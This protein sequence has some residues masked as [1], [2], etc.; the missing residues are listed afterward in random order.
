[1]MP[2]TV[3]AKTTNISHANLMGIFLA[4]FCLV[5]TTKEVS[6]QS[7]V[8]GPSV[9][10]SYAID[11]S[12]NLY[13]WGRNTVSQLG[14]G[15]TGSY[16]APD[17]VSFPPGVTKWIAVAGGSQG[18][19]NG[20]AVAVGNDGNAYAWGHGGN[21][22]MGDG[23][24]NS[25]G[26]PNPVT[27]PIGIKFTALAA[28]NNH[29]LALGNDGNVYAWGYNNKGQIGDGSFINR[30]TPFL[31]P[32]PSGITA[33]AI[34]AGANYSMA[35]RSDDSIEVWGNDGNGQLLNGLINSTGYSTPFA[36]SLPNG[37]K[38][39]A[40]SCGGFFALVLAND[41][42]LYGWGSA[43]KGQ[44]TGGDTAGLSYLTPH[45][46]IKPSGVTNWITMSGGQNY[47]MA[48]GD[49][50][51]LYATGDGSSGQLGDGVTDTS[52][53]FK[54]VV[55]PNGA[56]PQAISSGFATSMAS[57]DD[58]NVYAWG[59]N[60][61]GQVGIGNKVSPQTSPVQVLG[62]E[63]VGFLNLG[64]ISTP[65]VPVLLSPANS[66]ADQPVSISISWDSVANATSY[67]FQVSTDQTFASNLVANGISTDTSKALTGLVNSTTYYWRVR[68]IHYGAFSA[69]S[70]VRS[71]TTVSQPPTTPVLLSPVDNATDEPRNDTLVCSKA[72]NATHY[73]WQL[74]TN[75]SF[76][77]F[78]VNDSTTDT[79]RVV[80]LNAATKYYWQVRAVNP[81]GV[82][83]FGGP[84]S[85]T[86]INP[87]S[88]APTLILPA[89]NAT[90]Q[91]ADTL[92]T[93]W[94]S[95]S[96]ASGYAFQLSDTASFTR[97]TANDS[98]TDTMM[99]VTK[100]K[101]SQ[102]YYWRVSALNSG[103]SGPFSSADS[104]TTRISVPDVPVLVLPAAYVTGVPRITTFAWN[105]AARSNKYELQVST[106]FH[107]YTSG[108]SAGA[109]LKQN[110]VF[111][112]TTTDT[113]LQLHS[114]LAV[115]TKYYWHVNATD[116]AGWSGYANNPLFYFTT[117][118]ALSVGDEFDGIPKD[119][120]LSQNYPNPFNPS[121]TINYDLPKAQ[122]VTLKLYNVLGQEV[123]TLVNGHQNAGYYEVNFNASNLGSGVY[124]YVLRTEAFTSVHKM[125][126][127]K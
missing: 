37:L 113:T 94:H 80:S 1:M 77:S 54:N 2:S 29:C 27:M 96:K 111:D 109:F 12:G 49:N 48:I 62:K 86:V 65:S 8:S 98:T 95:V 79:M 114:P 102:K 108:D 32:L 82:S 72:A 83:T 13:T 20:F 119:F 89:N 11:A 58:G 28:G 99:A 125:M 107:V 127:L 36:I 24:T 73:H 81:G 117:G 85:F 6:A 15:N 40:I 115:S 4:L 76:S 105:K 16:Y 33:K 71:F 122:M 56:H 30:K 126:L 116:T 112:T 55:L 101:N 51:L 69:Y 34:A 5:L 120:A 66:A 53:F 92:V 23:S 39:K 74:S 19:T 21:G 110:V 97:F 118:T 57:G 90:F 7:V 88:T 121:T 106:D 26:A 61:S 3:L 52:A 42:N 91:R 41:G 9:Y 10:A 70:S 103:G 100:L 47:T 43:D 18:V 104:F 50:G 31:V 75:L 87:P 45:L 17:T 22:E 67:I 46:V 25:Y 124:F 64:I 59:L 123:A 60:D 93:M 38:A 14:H 78:V 84:D 35:L 63:G 44:F 68:S